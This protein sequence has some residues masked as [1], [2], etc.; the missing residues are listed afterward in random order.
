ME[1]E[2]MEIEDK[3]NNPRAT[4]GK[5]E[6]IYLKI[7]ES[8]ALKEFFRQNP[9]ETLRIYFTIR[10]DILTAM[11]TGFKN[12]SNFIDGEFKKTNTVSGKSTHWANAILNTGPQ[13]T[14]EKKEL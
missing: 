6:G 14:E 13:I 4:F 7:V 11:M 5:L 2:K 9:E 10:A 12:R 3:I 1:L 8:P